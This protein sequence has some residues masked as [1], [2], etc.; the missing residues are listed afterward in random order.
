MALFTNKL[1]LFIN[2]ETCR[3]SL[4]RPILWALFEI[5]KTISIDAFPHSK[6]SAIRMGLFSKLAP[7]PSS[8]HTLLLFHDLI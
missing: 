3:L 8:F 2:W 6:S 4:E 7:N 5:D 1:R